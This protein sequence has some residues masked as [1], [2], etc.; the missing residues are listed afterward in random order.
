MIT[1]DKGGLGLI[2]P[3]RALHS[4][5]YKE[6]LVKFAALLAEKGIENLASRGTYTK[7]HE[8]GI[9]V[10]NLEDF[11]GL[12]PVLDHR[13]ATLQHLLHMGIL[14]VRDSKFHVKEMNDKGALPIDI[15]NV[16]LYPFEQEL[17]KPDAN[18]ES[19]KEMIDIGG[20]TLLRGAAKNCEFATSICDKAL[21]P[22]IAYEL[23]A[24]EGITF[25][26][27]RLCA[28]RT[29]AHTS[30]YDAAVCEFFAADRLRR[31][32]EGV[33]DIVKPS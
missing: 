6:G 2:K 27:R 22:R 17:A 26:T 3:V 20:P 30:H 12:E 10:V 9:P 8:A 33:P 25:E 19:I 4:V 24:H 13:V 14:F 23:R 32:D 7:I 5:F 15:V 21:Y 31:R 11:T 16:G 28:E 29:F 1:R 18:F